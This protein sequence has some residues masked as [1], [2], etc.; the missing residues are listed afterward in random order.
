MMTLR[1]AVKEAEN[2]G[3]AIG[4]FNISDTEGLNAIFD[5][6]KSL[7]VPVII[8]T[9]EGERDFIGVNQAVALVKSLRE[10][11]N[12]PIYLNA[13]HTYSV[14]KVK[15][16][17]DAGYDAVIFDGTKLPFEENIEK[18]EEVV[19]YAKKSGR[20]VLV[21]GEI[22]YIGTSS[23]VLDEI[24]DGAEITEESL[25]K[26]DELKEYIDK[27]GVDL[28]APAVGNLH[29]V[30]K[31]GKN[32][33]ISI[34][35]IKELREVGGVPVV[36]HGGSGISDGEFSEAI[37]A[38]VSIIHLNTEIRLAYREGI[39]EVLEEKPDEIAP[40][41]FLKGGVEEMRELVEKRLKLFNNL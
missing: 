40:Y 24:P 38:G 27:T 35:R 32:P 11:H 9:S 1:E 2:K 8:G 33:N 20:D 39:E 37:K 4:H 10:E 13:D 23:K 34:E 30:L 7:N 14:E 5:A 36:L 17:I 29:G 19:E 16:A 25:T 41:R 12:F 15:E 21:E 3:V 22:G 18:T 6:A 26:P 31:K 28:V